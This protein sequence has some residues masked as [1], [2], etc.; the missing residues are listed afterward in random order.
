MAVLPG[1]RFGPYVIEGLLGAG[2]M[3]EVYR[4]LDTR[5]Q[6]AVAIKILPAHLSSDLQLHGRFLREA[7]LISAL[8]HPNVCAVYD[9]GSQD[10]IDFMVME[11]LAGQTL[12]KLIPKGGLPVELS[13]QYAVQ[14]AE[15]LSSAHAAGVVHRD[16]KPSN[17]LVEE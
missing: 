17:I 12:D 2:G 9:I 7:Q 14:I 8:Q 11:Y 10:G 15:A 6:R 13:I 16:L 1:T 4:A 5:L 3:G